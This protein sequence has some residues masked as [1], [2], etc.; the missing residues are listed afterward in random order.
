MERLGIEY[1]Q[2]T[3][4]QVHRWFGYYDVDGSGVDSD[5]V[6][7]IDA[8]SKKFL[9]G[10]YNHRHSYRRPY[11]TWAWEEGDDI[12]GGDS[13]CQIL[14]PIHRAISAYT[15]QRLE[16]ASLANG[17]AIITSDQELASKFKNRRVQPGEVIYC[18][19][20][21]TGWK[22]FKLSQPISELGGLINELNMAADK[23]VGLNDY[24]FGVEQVSRP[25]ASGQLALIEEGKQP[26]YQKLNSLRK[27]IG[28]LGIRILARYKQYWPDGVPY[29]RMVSDGQFEMML[30]SF[31]EGFIEDQVIIEPKASSANLNE[32]VRK[33]ETLALLE[34]MQGFYQSLMPVLM[35]AT[36]PGP[37]MMVSMKLALSMREMMNRVLDAFKI[38]RPEAINP[39]FTQEVMG[40]FQMAMQ[41]QLQGAGGQ[42]PGG[43]GQ[44]PG[45]G[46]PG[47][48]GSQ[49][50]SQEQGLPPSGNVGSGGA[51]QGNPS[52]AQGQ[53]KG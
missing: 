16:A 35:Q 36:M 7:E 5:I 20:L 32:G 19:D 49:P 6:V 42:G 10:S 4:I 50:G 29:Y 40:G 25:T 9:S 46:G 51:G 17:T 8:N 45:G 26:L 1:G 31:P 48:E 53:G 22:E 18:N 47:S 12:S 23:L 15:V 21:E 2:N 24:S 30:L 14:E 27:F 39:D 28:N 3:P 41:Q 13:L 34:Q 38:P 11:L 44:V 52:G 33:Q 43:A 37:G